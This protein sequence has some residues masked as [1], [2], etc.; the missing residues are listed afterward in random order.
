M[1][2]L[3][4]FII[5]NRKYFQLNHYNCQSLAFWT[6][7]KCTRGDADHYGARTVEHFKDFDM[8]N[9][10]DLELYNQNKGLY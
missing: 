10:E 1:S 6:S 7:I 9:T 5:V 3:S 4:K 8:N 2:N